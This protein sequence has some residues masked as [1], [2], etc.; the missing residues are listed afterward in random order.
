MQGSPLIYWHRTVKGKLNPIS[1][2]HT[3]RA[4]RRR[5]TACRPPVP[6][7]RRDYGRLLAILADGTL[8]IRS[9][10]LSMALCQRFRIQ[11]AAP[12]RIGSYVSTDDAIVAWA[13]GQLALHLGC[14][15]LA[16][17]V[18][19]SISGSCNC[20]HSRRSAVRRS[21]APV[22]CRKLQTAQ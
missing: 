21:L 15:G 3:S 18:G 5:K 14:G 7:A 4:W 8:R 9:I 11:K 10:A 1:D 12:L 20:R 17:K 2:G 16:R 22:R 13:R 6:R 19:G